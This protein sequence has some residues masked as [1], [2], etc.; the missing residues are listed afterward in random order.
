MGPQYGPQSKGRLQIVFENQRMFTT[1]MILFGTLNVACDQVI[2]S[3]V[4]SAQNHIKLAD[5]LHSR[6]V[7]VLKEVE[8]RTKRQK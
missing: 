6:V 3:I 7:E 5:E 2:M 1:F 4:D 8:R